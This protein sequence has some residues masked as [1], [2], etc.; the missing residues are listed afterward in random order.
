M[1]HG[2]RPFQREEVPRKKEE[3]R[4]GKEDIPGRGQNVEKKETRL[5]EGFTLQRG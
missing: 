1:L 5:R 3:G 4:Q 2:L